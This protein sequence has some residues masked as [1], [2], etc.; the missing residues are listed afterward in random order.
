MKVSNL[1][2]VRGI[3]IQ[4]ALE[5]RVV[6][7]SD[8][9]IEMKRVG[10]C[11]SD[12]HYYTDGAIGSQLVQYPWTAGHEGAGVV[13]EVGAAV[14]RVKVGDR[15]A[16]DPCISCGTCDQCV[17]GR[18]HTCR[19]QTF[20]GCPGQ[21]PGCL[22]ERIVLPAECCYPVPDSLTFDDAALVE[23]LSIAVHA[24]NLAGSLAGLSVGILGAGPI[25][26]CTLAVAKVDGPAQVFVTDK[27][28]RRVDA[29]RQGGADWA[30]N[31]D[32]VDVVAVV[33]E[34]CPLQLDV[35]F[36]CTGDQAA[37]DQAITLL[38]PGGKLMLVGIPGGHNRIS[39]EINQLRRKEIC[40]QNVRRQ[41]E[42]VDRAID[43]IA[44]GKVDIRYL[45]T[46]HF[47]FAKTR[48]AF[49]L[50]AGY[51]DGVLKAMIELA[52]DSAP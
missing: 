11:G 30:G 47:P 2:D 28:D 38:A 46:H 7:P 49:E 1:T 15:V 45:L 40:V 27:I 31:P 21:A 52:Q 10:V 50:V 17:R 24:V 9:L 12:I 14:K 8:V 13:R 4:D 29:A 16:F 18:R 5:P 23:P 25:G 20:L 22:A 36:E 43:L 35:V 42:C 39:M 37:I 3:E 44:S 19:H 33:G 41:N 48:D 6:T 51:R 34:L 26:L 32:Q